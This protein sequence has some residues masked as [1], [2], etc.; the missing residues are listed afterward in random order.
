MYYGSS[1]GAEVVYRESTPVYA[2]VRTLWQ[3]LEL[4]YHLISAGEEDALELTKLN[5]ASKE[6]LFPWAFYQL[7][8]GRDF[9]F[10]EHN[11]DCGWI[12]RGKPIHVPFKKWLDHK[13]TRLALNRIVGRQID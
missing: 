8:G 9:Q 10:L 4:E 5:K 2:L 11:Q 3:P 12:L 6:T 1:I 7:A 13:V